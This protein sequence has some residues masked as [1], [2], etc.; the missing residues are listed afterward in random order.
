[1]GYLVFGFGLRIFCLLQV[2]G[3]LTNTGHDVKLVLDDTSNSASAAY[4]NI[5]GGPLAYQYRIHELSIH[6][7]RDDTR[8]S[9]HSIENRHF[10]A[11]VFRFTRA[12]LCYR[13]IG[14][15]SVCLSVRLSVKNRYC[16]EKAERIDF[17]RFCREGYPR[18]FL[19]CVGKEFRYLQKISILSSGTLSQTLDLENFATAR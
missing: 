8:G 17:A 3:T 18:F 13:G 11:E 6:F 2:D 1:M 9:E 16:I 4:V 10:P 19:H 7:G 14:Y 15:G 12:T 5:S